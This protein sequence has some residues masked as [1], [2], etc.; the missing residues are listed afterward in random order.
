MT[1]GAPAVRAPPAWPPATAA[2]EATAWSSGSVGASGPWYAAGRRRPRH[3][4][5]ASSSASSD[6][7]AAGSRRCC[8]WSAACSAP[9]PARSRSRAAPPTT[10]AAAQAV[11]ARAAD[12]RPCCPWRTVRQNVRLLTEVNKGAEAHATLRPDETEAL[13]DEVGLGEFLDAYPQRALRR[14]AAAGQPRARLRPRRADPAHGRAVR[15]ARRDDPRG[16]CASCCCGC[17]SA[18]RP[19]VVFVTHHIPEA[20]ML[21]DRVLVMSPRPGRIVADEPDRPAPAPHRRAQ[22]DDAGLRRARH[23]ACAGPPARPAES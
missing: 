14:H 7:A 8:G 19:T 2:I 3:R 17:G 12:A 23:S 13:L 18:P 4:A 10:G 20:V 16:A 15:R 1:D 9:T 11:R 21:S 22:E 6:R 5:R